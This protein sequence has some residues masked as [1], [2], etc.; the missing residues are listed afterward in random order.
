LETLSFGSV[1]EHNNVVAWP[2]YTLVTLTRPYSEVNYFRPGV[3][4]NRVFSEVNE[5]LVV[6]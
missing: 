5:S 1:I 2:Y 3:F 6:M 4:G